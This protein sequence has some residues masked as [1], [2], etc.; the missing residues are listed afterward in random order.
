MQ[1]RYM[2]AVIVG[3]RPLTDRITELS[4]RAADG[5]PLPLAEA[6]SHIEL[7]FGGEGGRFLRHYSIVG[8]LAADGDAEGF[9]RIAVQREDRSRGSAFIH[10]NFTPGTHLRVSRPFNAF[11]LSRGKP[12]HLLVAGGIGITPILAM[13]R[14]LY[15]RHE[16]FSALYLGAQRGAMAYADEMEA[17][18]GPRLTLRQ[19]ATE[20]VPD[21]QAL[22]AMQPEGTQV[23]V[24]GPSGLIEALVSAAAA[25]DWVPGRIR[26][27]IFNAAHQPGDQPF[28]VRLKNGTVVPVGAGTTILDALEGAGV[29]TFADCRRGECGLCTTDVIGCDGELD[30]RDHFFTDADR[31][32]GRQMTICCSRINGRV[33][34]LDL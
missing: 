32:A 18:C 27:E 13:A 11:R 3:R 10:A 6:G 1:D 14:S 4:I 31:A 30:H 9:W 22:L 2:D 19:T 33:L 23:Y 28:E 15:T 20:G 26:Y 8:P 21:L 34:E 29:E 17:L 25:L 7:R 12:H 16:S 24:C 5:R